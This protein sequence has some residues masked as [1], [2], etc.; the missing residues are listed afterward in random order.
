MDAFVDPE[1]DGCGLGDEGSL[2]KV[3]PLVTSLDHADAEDLR[4]F[5][6]AE[7]KRREQC[8]SDVCE[9]VCEERQAVLEN[10]E[11]LEHSS[12]SMLL[13]ASWAFSLFLFNASSAVRG[14][15]GKPG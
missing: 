5:L 8:G 9:E 10:L 1:S 11:E 6:E 13:G 4:E 3:F 12:V 15:R 7:R 14:G 2:G